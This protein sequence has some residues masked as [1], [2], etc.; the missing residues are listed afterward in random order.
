MLREGDREMAAGV[1]VPEQNVSDSLPR[2]NERRKH[3][4]GEGKKK[5][6]RK[7]EENACQAQT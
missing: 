4:K 3:R 5:E 7:N 6:D 1:V 2:R